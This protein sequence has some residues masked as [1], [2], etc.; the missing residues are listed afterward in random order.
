MARKNG[1]PGRPAKPNVTRTHLYLNDKVLKA[2]VASALE[3][4]RT[5]SAQMEVLVGE[6]FAARGVKIVWP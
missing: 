4:N 6:A 1:K 2:V 3:E 5:I